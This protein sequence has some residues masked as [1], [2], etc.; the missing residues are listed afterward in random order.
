[1][2]RGTAVFLALAILLA[3]TLAIHQTP[4]GEFAAPYEIAHVAF[5]LGRN[6]VYEGSALWNPGSEPAESYPSQ[7][8]IALS[9]LAA[10]LYASPTV[11][12]Q[13][14]GLACALASIVVL[15]QFSPRRTAGLIAPLLLAA[16]G[17]VAAAAASGTEAP[18]AMLIATAAFLAFERG[19]ARPLAILLCAL[20]L[21]RPEAL[22][23]LAA[24][25]LLERF[26]RPG[27]VNARRP[28]CWAAFVPPF[29]LVLVSLLARRVLLGS[30]LSPFGASFLVRESERWWLGT[31]YLWSFVYASGFGLLL[32]AL[33]PSLL[34]R[35]TSP[36]AERALILSLAWWLAVLIAGGDGLPFWNALAPVLPL[37]FLAIQECLREWMDHRAALT[38]VVWPLLLLSVTASFL[39]S[40]V[41]GDLGPLPIE[42]ALTR[43]QQP[44]ETLA[45]AYDRRPLGRLG[46]L[47]EIRTVEHLRPLGVFLRD[48][49][50]A[51]ATIATLWPGAIGYL[52][53]KEVYDLLGR[54]W[55]LPGEQRSRSWRGVQQVDPI[56]ALARPADY[57]VP[58]VGT[59]PESSAPGDILRHWLQHYDVSEESELSR[60]LIIA[61]RGYE[62]VCVPVPAKSENPREPSERAFPLLRSKELGLSPA[63]SIEVEDQ[64]FRVLVSHEGHQQVVDLHV[65][66]SDDRGGRW[67]LR[68]T[69]EWTRWVTVDARTSVL[70]YPTGPRRIRMVE[71]KL[72]A[73]VPALKLTAWLHNPGMR[74]EAALSQ[75]GAPFSIELRQ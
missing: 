71:A 65:Q 45:R 24:L 72:P 7:L 53:R 6:L 69:G 20:L 3:H 66:L 26:G 54:A 31:Q 21:T 35:R 14:V 4:D 60:R 27:T 57:L 25:A 48:K 61:L 50:E 12:A 30:W 22:A 33:V 1:M 46:L 18:L 42:G 44:P 56:G 39:V 2:N 29:L 32:L 36:M 9:A 34:A 55:P 37:I 38:V 58:A 23:F 59:L 15:A 19:A 28:A 17:S 64:S 70:L 10:R 5:R 49:V 75:V 11:L 51:D 41:P 73:G 74:P 8:W 43:W 13:A 63:L 62:L 52:S 68:P 16:S 40:K 67:S 47:D